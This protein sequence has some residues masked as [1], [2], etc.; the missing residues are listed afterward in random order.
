[1]RALVR[2]IFTVLTWLASLLMLTLG[3]VYYRPIETL[4]VLDG[5]SNFA[6]VLWIFNVLLALIWL[7]F[8]SKTAWVPATAVLLSLLLFENY[9]R[10]VSESHD[11]E[12]DGI[13]VM[14]YNT[15]SFELFT[16]GR[17]EFRANNMLDFILAEDPDILCM[18]EFSYEARRFLIKKFPYS[19]ITQRNQG[20]TIQAIFSKYPIL[21]GAVI[22]F[23]ESRNST[24]YADIGIEND[25]LRV[26]NVHLQSYRVEGLRFIVRDY[27]MWFTNRLAEVSKMRRSQVAIIRNHMEQSPFSNLICGDFNAPPFTPTYRNMKADMQDT[28]AKHGSGLGTTFELLRIPYRIDYILADSTYSVLHHRTY[29]VPY[30]DHFPISA[31]LKPKI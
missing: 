26:Y 5:F 6:H 22:E 3:L 28:F 24:I 29:D 30:S 10:P 17:D 9:Y 15:H 11:S 8:R 14:S 7:L 4:P 13:K 2:F 25:T 31:I 19:Y 16:W 23:P 21:S 1:M 12:P 20:K 27:G 18:Q